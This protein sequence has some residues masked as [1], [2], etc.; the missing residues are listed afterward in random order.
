MV[1]DTTVLSNFAMIGQVSLLEQL[2]RQHA[3]TALM[4]ADEIHRGLAAGYAQLQVALD[5][6]SPSAAR[7]A[8]CRSYRWKPPTE[9][10]LYMELIAS[11]GPGEA[12]CL[13]LAIALKADF[14]KRR[15]GCSAA[16]RPA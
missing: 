2:Y 7:R 3:C 13:A 8:G 9:Q 6:L 15:S 1:L 11:L 12:A 5:I 16:G 10:A 4:V 14:G